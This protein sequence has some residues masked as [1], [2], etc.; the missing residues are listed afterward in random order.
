MGRYSR[1]VCTLLGLEIG[2]GEEHCTARAGCPHP[3]NICAA[4]V[5]AGQSPRALRGG[6]K[7]ARRS[8]GKALAHQEQASSKR[9]AFKKGL[10]ARRERGRSRLTPA[11]AWICRRRVWVGAALTSLLF[12]FV[13][14]ALTRTSAFWNFGAGVSSHSSPQ[15]DEAA[16]HTR[17]LHP[18][19]VPPDDGQHVPVPI[20][21][22]IV[23]GVSPGLP[24]AAEEPIQPP[25]PESKR[26]EPKQAV[27]KHTVASV[28]ASHREDGEAQAF[29]AP[30]WIQA[31]QPGDG[32]T[33]VLPVAPTLSARSPAEHCQKLA[34]DGDFDAF[35]LL[36]R[37]YRVTVRSQ[38]PVSSRPEI[39]AFSVR[40]APPAPYVDAV[41]RSVF[42]SCIVSARVSGEGRA[43]RVIGLESEQASVRVRTLDV[44]FRSSK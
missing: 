5:R 21:I 20:R 16:A 3:E 1:S 25:P 27:K 34:T 31:A 39:V 30:Q 37:R 15:S 29:A 32:V 12:H 36:P 33:N 17:E 24:S 10:A 38:Q 2:T 43:G 41:L 13:T 35:G 19:E 11:H 44:E 14:G 7:I 4:Q 28:H 40:S 22:R 8:S 9:H 42:E 18:K 23:R 6:I 26:A